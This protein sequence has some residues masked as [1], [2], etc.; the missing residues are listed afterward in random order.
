MAL[1]AH[2]SPSRP[3]AKA[4]SI[5]ALGDESAEL[6]AVE[7]VGARAEAVDKD[8]PADPISPQPW[9]L[10]LVHN[11][12][13]FQRNDPSLARVLRYLRGGQPPA[14]SDLKKENAEVVQL[15]REWDRLA[16]RDNVLLRQ[17]LTDGHETFQLILPAEFR[18][19]AL[20]GLHDDVGHPGRDP[21]LDLVR[22][23]FYWPFMATHIGKYVDHCGRCIRRKA[24]DPP[25]APMKSFIAKEPMELLAMDFLSLEKG[26]GGFENI[27]VVTDS[28][29]IFSW[30][31]PTRD[32][33]ATTVAKLLREKIFINYGMPQRLHS[34]QGRDFEGKVIKS[35]CPF[36]GIR[37]SRTT[38]YHPQGNGQTERFNKTL[39]SMFGTLD[40]DNKSRWPEYLSHLVYAYNCTKLSTTEFSPFLLMFGREP[41]LP[42][43][44]ALGVHSATL[45]QDR[46]LLTLRISGIA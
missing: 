5:D 46:T 41:D 39:L 23:R 26:K 8:L 3:S 1:P 24:P 25:R 14:G 21:T 28:L 35:L 13:E 44:V 31:F 7:V 12:A 32:Q 10:N 43:D 18:N 20:R 6:P 29:T 2:T 30:A 42:I 22:S 11:W 45:D 9:H 40:Q 34:D 16:I 33:R 17:R 4:Y 37:K 15:I 38:P 27:L 36:A 19:Q